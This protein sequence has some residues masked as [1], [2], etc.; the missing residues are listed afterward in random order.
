MND[1]TLLLY[2]YDDG[3]S[4]A[5]RR[6]VE[7]ALA[8]DPSLAA[9]YRALACDLARLPDARTVPPSAD[10]VQRWHDSIAR[11][12]GQGAGEKPGHRFHSWSFLLGAVAAAA[13]AVGMGLGIFLAADRPAAPPPALAVTDGG[14][15]AAG[16]S[17]AFARELRLYLRQSERSLAMLSAEGNGERA[18]LLMGLIEQN[19]LY[20]RAARQ[21]DA[22]DVARVLRAFELVLV[23]LAAGDIAPAE[24]EAL[25]AKLRFELNVMLTKLS[26]GSSDEPQSI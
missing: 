16:A 26:R 5:E 12:A 9:R 3:L 19:R 2:Y 23:E 24:A 4:V 11:A 21:S 13:L 20:A 7:R 8:A 22:E 15:A 1:D 17:P 25:R 14:T 6:E 18:A 10:M